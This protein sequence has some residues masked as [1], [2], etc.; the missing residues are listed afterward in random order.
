MGFQMIPHPKVSACQN[1][2]CDG[3]A[4]PPE[5]FCRDCQE[6]NAAN[7][8]SLKREKKKGKHEQQ[9]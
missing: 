3:N 6:A 9:K 2:R 4:H 8:E 1:R 7:L 5:L